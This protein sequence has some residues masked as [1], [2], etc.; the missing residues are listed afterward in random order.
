[1]G[2]DWASLTQPLM[3]GQEEHNAVGGQP[4]LHPPER[5]SAGLGSGIWHKQGFGGYGRCSQPPGW[6]SALCWGAA[7]CGAT[8]WEGECVFLKRPLHEMLVF[9]CCPLLSSWC[10]WW[11]SQCPG[12]T[13]CPL[14]GF[15][16]S[17]VPEQAVGWA[18]SPGMLGCLGRR[19]VRLCPAQPDP[20]GFGTACSQQ[21]RVWAGWHPCTRER[22]GW[23]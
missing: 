22:V 5:S 16:H 10:R 13:A 11:V 4:G 21:A 1:M 23:E 6:A 8:S 14:L 7:L 15:G 3:M 19:S 2:W 18:G 9:L 17:R 12:W 20:Q